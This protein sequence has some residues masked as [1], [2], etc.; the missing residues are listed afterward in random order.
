MC[1]T[2]NRFF[3]LW[4]KHGKRRKWHGGDGIASAEKPAKRKKRV[5]VYGVCMAGMFLMFTVLWLVQTEICSEEAK[6]NTELVSQLLGEMEHGMSPELAVAN[7][8]KG[9]ESHEAAAAGKKLLAGYGYRPDSE[10]VFTQRKKTYAMWLLKRYL[11]CYLL[12]A[13]ML[14]TIKRTMH[15]R[16][17]EELASLGEV[18]EQFCRGDY[19]FAA[20]DYGE[21]TGSMLSMR[22]ESLGKKLALNEERLCREKEETKTLVTDLSHQLKTPLAS[23]KMSYQLLEEEA[24][25]PEERKEFMQRMGE[26]LDHLGGLLE[27]LMNISRMESGLIHIQ[28]EKAEIFKTLVQAINQVYMKAEQKGIEMEICDTA[29]EAE[30]V[31]LWHDVKWTKETIVNILDNAIK[32]S[33][34]RS[35]VWISMKKQTQFL[36]IEIKDE[37]IGISKEEANRVFQRFYRG[38]NAVVKKTEGS[39]VGLYLARKILEEQGGNI[40]IAFTMGKEKVCGTRFVLL[41]PLE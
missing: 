12:L 21:E 27:A 6:K 35:H 39:G 32:Y 3:G 24:L 26:Q 34:A 5:P 40:M 41:L 25:T 11:L 19:Q 15:K 33:P 18:L 8:L 37:G 20:E 22:L 31:M 28:K 14:Y 1:G 10:T 17:T 9:N 13:G 23:V 4:G 38:K 16:R 7:L 29:K 30:Q 2:D 36:R